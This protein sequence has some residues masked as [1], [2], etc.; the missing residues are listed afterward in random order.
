VREPNIPQIEADKNHGADTAILMATIATRTVETI[1]KP[2]RVFSAEIF[3]AHIAVTKI[4]ISS[5]TYNNK[6]ISRDVAD[7]PNN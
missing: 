5:N 6:R 4:P 3:D 7:P 2:I 1:L